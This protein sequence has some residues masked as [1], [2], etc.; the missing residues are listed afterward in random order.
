M[1]RSIKCLLV[2]PVLFI[3]LKL[4]GQI[5][6]TIK[7]N[8]KFS[9]EDN[10]DKLRVSLYLDSS[11]NASSDFQYYFNSGI[12]KLK[13]N[14]F[15]HAISDFRTSLSIL[16]STK[17]EKKDST[18]KS[19]PSPLLYIGICKLN[20]N[21]VDSA[22]FYYKK[23]ISINKSV[24]EA[25]TELGRASLFKGK[26]D[27]AIFFFNECYK[28]NNKNL[29]TNYNLGYSYFLT[30]D[31]DK[32]KTYLNNA[33][34]IESKF[35]L[36]YIILG[37]ISTSENNY[38]T[39]RKYY[40]SAIDA[41]DLATVGYYYRGLSYMRDNKMD[42][43]Y[44]DFERIYELD[45]L[46]YEVL[47]IVGFL[48]INS[49]RFEKGI[50]RLAKCASLKTDKSYEQQLDDYKK[51]ELKS[52]IIELNK[53]EL[54]ADEK[55]LGFQFL[56]NAFNNDW[57][58][59][60]DITLEFISKNN[61]SLFAKRLYILS[62]TYTFFFN[63]NIEYLDKIISKD[64]SL[65]TI[66]LLKG[67]K[68]LEKGKYNE[69][70]DC[71]SKALKNQ[72]TKASAYYYRG[73]AYQFLN[74]H[75]NAI[76]DFS[77]LL[78]SYT[79]LSVA[80]YDRGVSYKETR[81]ERN[82]IKDF[83]NSINLD[84]DIS[85]YKYLMITECYI[86]LKQLDSALYYCNKYL[87]KDSLSINSYNVINERGAVYLEM[88]DYKR[89]LKDLNKVISVIPKN[90]E[91][92][93]LRGRLLFEI[94]EYKLAINDFT[95]SL[96]YYYLNIDSNNNPFKNE[97]YK[98]RGDAFF[99]NGDYDKAIGDFQSALLTNGNDPFTLKRVGDCYYEKKYIQK[100][101]QY[102]DLSIE[103]D[104]S[105]S[106]AY[107]QKGLCYEQINNKEY[108]VQLYFK[109]IALDSTFS[110]PYGSLARLYYNDGDFK[111]CISYSQ[112]AYELD[113]GAFYAMYNIALANLRL[114]QF[115]VAKRYYQIFAKQNIKLNKVY[116][117]GAIDDLNELINKGI[118][119]NESK[120]ILRDVF[121]ILI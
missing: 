103:K 78:S 91:S 100:A 28:R 88:K 77:T 85:Y 48:D 83:K 97:L 111:K 17:I 40:T 113:K 60:K 7:T 52:L 102:Y 15:S 117:Q 12:K 116:F 25:Y 107:Y 118:L 10:W 120:E 19:V 74:K 11:Y 76:K 105:L 90:V 69:S 43:A 26:I 37:Q 96:A 73:K 5:D 54:L 112:K 65:T 16:N 94:G 51:I 119:V 47:N 20:L 92:F 32:A 30:K 87:V 22:I 53:G 108:A 14:D 64:S 71:F 95:S 4:F 98:K 114:N 8:E 84:V 67:V 106:I 101:I 89:A 33:I 56:K 68:L 55:E 70:I 110:L 57:V 18:I 121:K 21:E 24:D 9:I 86:K 72:Q 63:F 29:T 36:P 80:Y 2:I 99:Y 42:L 31:F 38:T 61:E 66:I 3:N 104:S 79:A 39:A 59:N 93:K 1:L 23:C 50:S 75:D 13:V 62:N 58:K 81:D 115:A 82:A 6:N 27:T 44:K 41:D 35:N 109:A 46:N 34:D 45:S 49:D